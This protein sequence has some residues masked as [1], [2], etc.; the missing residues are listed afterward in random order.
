LKVKRI[1]LIGPPGGGK[2]TQA[3]QLEAD[4]GITQLST[5]DILRE[6]ISS[7]SEL[8]EKV[9]DTIEGGNLVSD[10]VMIGLIKERLL[11]NESRS[12]FI[13]DGFPRTISQA[14]ALNVFLA[15]NEMDLDAVIEIN[16]PDELLIERITGRFSCSNC[17]QGYHDTF[18]MPKVAGIC[19]ECGGTDFTRRKDDNEETVKNRLVAYNEQTSPLISFYRKI[20]ILSVI[21]G[22]QDI[23]L[24]TKC[25][26]EVLDA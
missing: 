7:G 4:Y 25:I 23:K 24:V 16:V 22:N 21:D 8:G 20:G 2:G 12:G 9:K 19:D 10:E 15:E 5:G 26:K 3:K 14:K 11:A 18:N 6:A 1:I 13:L 17:G